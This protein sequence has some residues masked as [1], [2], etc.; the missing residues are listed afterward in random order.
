MGNGSGLPYHDVA[1]H[2]FSGREFRMPLLE[3]IQTERNCGFVTI[4]VVPLHNSG[5]AIEACNL[6]VRHAGLTPPTSYW[7]RLPSAAANL[8]LVRCL[9]RDLAYGAPC[10]A[11]ARAEELALQFFAAVGPGPHQFF[12]NTVPWVPSVYE[13]AKS[14]QETGVLVI[15]EDE[16]DELGWGK[17]AHASVSAALSESTFDTG[18]VVIGPDIGGILWFEDED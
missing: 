6:I 17:H 14:A 18:I 12:T 5:S 7:V 10:M 8:H 9:Q 16:V 13:R 2:P 1:D 15:A 4:D 3:V 11:K